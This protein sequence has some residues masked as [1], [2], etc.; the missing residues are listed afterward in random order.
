MNKKQETNMI[1]I[2]LITGGARSGKSTFA[3][4]YSREK[5]IGVI[6][7]IAYIATSEIMDNEFEK[8]IKIH[9]ER[10]G[11]E[12]ETYEESLEFMKTIHDNFEKHDVFI[13]EC[14]TTWLGNIFYK[15]FNDREKIVENMIDMLSSLPDDG[16]KKIIFVSNE[17]GLGIV[18]DNLMARDFRDMQGRLNSRIASMASEVYFAVSGIPMKIK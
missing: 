5:N 9:R 1:N 3:E 17:V 18:P 14:L 10:R 11:S 16:E 8:R 6:K 2:V 4:K 7:Q 13:I 15:Q 12:F